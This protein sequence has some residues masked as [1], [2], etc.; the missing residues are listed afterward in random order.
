MRQGDL[1]AYLSDEE[2]ARLLAAMD[3][4]AV[5][6]GE[7]ILHKDS[8]SR[9]LLLVAEG[10]VEVLDEALGESVV[11]ARLGPGSV[12]GEVGFVDGRPR[13][14][15]VWAK[16]DCRLRRLTRETLLSLARE[17]A[18]L[19]AKL[20]I[21]LAELLAARFRSAVR[22]LEPLR[23]FGATLEEPMEGAAFDEVEEELPESALEMLRELAKRP[24]KDAAGI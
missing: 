14:H 18:T 2:Q 22:E 19:F 21:G 16:T 7:P 23:A 11:L 3:E 17:D 4:T 9:S 13:T 15:D 6:A 10:Q 5:G 20:V 24:G 12:F 1:V 8:P